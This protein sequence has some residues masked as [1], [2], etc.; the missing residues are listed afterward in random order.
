MRFKH[1]TFYYNSMSNYHVIVLQTQVVDYNKFNLLFIF[2][3]QVGPSNVGSGLQE[4]ILNGVEIMKMSNDAQSLDGLFS[5]DGTYMGGPR[6]GTMKIVA[7]VG[8]AMGVVA[9]LF[10]AVVF[11]RWQR[12][13][14]GWEKRNS[15]SSWLLPLH[16][17]HSTLFSS[18]SSSRRSS[19]FGSRRVS[20]TGFS[21]IYTNV[22]LGRYFSLHELQVRILY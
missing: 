20:K 5:V 3:T 6:F 19:V 7:I 13:P 9:V 15:F 4:A 16:S 1:K 22:G 11:L 21:G 10:L 17:T 18:K 14:Q 2:L 8:L 12:R